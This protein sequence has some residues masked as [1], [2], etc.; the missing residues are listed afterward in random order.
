MVLSNV[1]EVGENSLMQREWELQQ[2]KIDGVEQ[3]G[4]TGVEI[5][6]RNRGTRTT[7][8]CEK[9][10]ENQNEREPE[11]MGL[12]GQSQQK[13]EISQGHSELKEVGSG[14]SQSKRKIKGKKWKLQARTTK[15]KVRSPN[16]LTGNKRKGCDIGYKSP[17][18][19]KI[20]VV[21]LIKRLIWN[22]QGSFLQSELRLNRKATEEATMQAAGEMQE[23][24][25]AE[26]GQQP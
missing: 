15:V 6:P 14:T 2:Q 10:R 13:Q 3:I 7:I 4:T 11:K 19:K 18:K 20:K 16:E 23:E 12:M 8:E 1:A 25:L 24:I 9:E 26:A 21:S 17:E 5:F 22:S